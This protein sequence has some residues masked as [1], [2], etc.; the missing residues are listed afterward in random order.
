M[1]VVAVQRPSLKLFAAEP[2]FVH[3]QMERM[4]VVVPFFAHGP[5]LSPQFVE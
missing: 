1:V 5:Q 3:Q 4:L 2:A